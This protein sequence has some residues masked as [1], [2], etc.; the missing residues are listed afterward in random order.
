MPGEGPRFEATRFLLAS[1]V[2][3]RAFIMRLS[4]VLSDAAADRAARGADRGDKEG[5]PLETVTTGLDELLW[6]E[7]TRGGERGSRGEGM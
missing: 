7:L 2:S 6:G 3:C 5:L 1:D 4:E